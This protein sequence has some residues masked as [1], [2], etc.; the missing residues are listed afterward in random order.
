MKAL[1][2]SKVL[3]LEEIEFILSLE[4]DFSSIRGSFDSGDADKDQEL[5]DQIIEASQNSLWAWCCV[6]VTARWSG[7]EGTASIGGVSIL[8]GKGHGFNI[9]DTDASKEKFFRQEMGYYEDL[10]NEAIED[11]KRNL[12]ENGWK[13]E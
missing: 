7:M 8:P 11:L 13:L 10:K 5:E 3:F 6:V 2:V 1:T 9:E 12:I 4:E